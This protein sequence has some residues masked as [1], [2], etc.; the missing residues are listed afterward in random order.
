[1]TANGPV[2][3]DAELESRRQ[4]PCRWPVGLPGA[5]DEALALSIAARHADAVRYVAAW[6]R[7]HVWDG[8]RWRRDE[9]LEVGDKV[10]ALCR[11]STEACDSRRAAA[12]SEGP[13][14]RIETALAIVQARPGLAVFSAPSAGNMAVIEPPPWAR[15]M[16]FCADAD[17]V[18]MIAASDGARRMRALGR[19]A[20]VA[21]PPRIG[22]DF[23][24]VLV[25]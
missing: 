23:N 24:D 16:I 9:I 5:S 19:R 7:W 8:W 25:A 6:G 14:R 2:L 1:M 18:G 20:A 15:E 22:K 10:R 4:N 21:V 12:E 3:D 11:E 17:P 13:S